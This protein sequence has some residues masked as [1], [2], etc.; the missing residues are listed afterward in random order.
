MNR[1]DVDTLI[2]EVIPHAQNAIEQGD[3]KVQIILMDGLKQRIG[4]WVPKKASIAKEAIETL[5]KDYKG[6]FCVEVEAWLLMTI[7]GAYY[8]RD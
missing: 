6:R 7:D 4:L 2:E 3:E 5:K 8:H 1:A